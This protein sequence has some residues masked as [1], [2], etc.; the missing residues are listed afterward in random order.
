MKALTSTVVAALGLWGCGGGEPEAAVDAPRDPG[1]P[2]GSRVNIPLKINGTLYTPDEVQALFGNEQLCFFVDQ[3]ARK[4]GFAY[5]FTSEGEWQAFFKRWERA[6][7]REIS[8]AGVEQTY[9]YTDINNGGN[10]ITVDAYTAVPDLKNYWCDWFRC[11]DW[12]D[13][14]SSATGS[15]INRLTYLY[16]HSNYGG[17][18]VALPNDGTRVNLT[19]LG[20]NDMASSVGYVY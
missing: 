9:L 17:R 16:E 8:T 12:N 4:Q 18:W 7:P 11:F 1:G 13:R 3:D 20:F 6:H 15:R 5:A 10:Y 19:D 14:A 2:A